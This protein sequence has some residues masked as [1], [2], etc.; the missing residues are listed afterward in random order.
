[1][2]STKM[3]DFDGE[4]LLDA[5]AGVDAAGMLVMLR[6]VPGVRIGRR[7]RPA[8]QHRE[9]AEIDEAADR[10]AGA[11]PVLHRLHAGLEIET[12][13]LIRRQ[14]LQQR[15]LADAGRSE[16]RERG[17]VLRRRQALV[18]GDNPNWHLLLL[19]IGGGG[20]LTGRRRMALPALAERTTPP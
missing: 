14:G 8:D 15:C 19:Q 9:I 12:D 20:A 17:L 1:M 11:G 5:G 7:I 16:D 10:N 3:I 18:G 13:G 6:A 2:L 4:E